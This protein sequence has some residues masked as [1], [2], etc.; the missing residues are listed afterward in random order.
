[1][2]QINCR[3]DFHPVGQGLFYS[4]QLCSRR[5]ASAPNPE[6]FDFVYD[7]G[8]SNAK[9]YITDALDG[10][11]VDGLDL[12]VISHFHADHMNGVKAL[13]GKTQ[14]VREVVLPYLFPAERLLAGAGY[15]IANDLDGL[16]A[17]YISFLVDPV[18][19]LTEFGGDEA[20]ITFLRPGEAVTEWPDAGDQAAGT[21]GW[22]PDAAA[23]APDDPEE[24]LSRPNV[25]LRLHS[26]IYRVPQWGF[27]FY[28][29]PGRASAK[30]IE[31]QM[32]ALTPPITL[33]DLA[34]VLS[35]RLDD[36]KD[37]YHALFDGSAGQ[38]STSVVCCH[39][40]AMPRGNGGGLLHGDARIGMSMS[41][42][43]QIHNVHRLHECWIGHF[44]F[45]WHGWWPSDEER[46]FLLPPMQLL[47]GDANL[48]PNEYQTH[49]AHELNGVGLA[50]LPHH[51]SKHN[52][53]KGFPT[54]MPNCLLWVAS[55][56]LGNRH[57]H[58]HKTVVDAVVDANRQL[59][60]CN[61]VQHV[62]IFVDGWRSP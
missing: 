48:K 54:M 13:L 2:T 62:A 40:P 44:L 45:D 27:K 37:L 25:G 4:G 30:D 36:L 61:E 5:D 26:S 32:A 19:Y 49:F 53:R 42:P 11:D 6:R 18:G 1:M 24:M 35:D 22:Y 56:G 47:T 15:A 60:T 51:G 8:T 29:Q 9:R 20:N 33:D 39:G 7:C 12:L 17:D 28:C 3:F 50:L 38:N 46:P 58:P 14:G 31:R 55:F 57:K 34:V 41:P 16:D 52:W 21:Y 59:V 43:G 10:Y 23:P